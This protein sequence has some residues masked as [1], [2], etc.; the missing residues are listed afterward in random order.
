MEHPQNTILHHIYGL[1]RQ[2]MGSAPDNKN[3]SKFH[4]YMAFHTL[5]H[6]MVRGLSRIPGSKNAIFDLENFGPQM[7]WESSDDIAER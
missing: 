2:E 7:V 1:S 5:I 6:S 4:V 3:F